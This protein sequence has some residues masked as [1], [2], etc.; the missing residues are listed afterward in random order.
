VSGGVPT[1]LELAGEY[2][3]DGKRPDGMSLIPWPWILPLLWDFTC[4]CTV[5][6]CRVSGKI[7]KYSCL[8]PSLY[9]SPICV[10]TLGAWG[11]CARSLVRQISPWVMEQSGDNRATQF[12]IQKVAIDVQRGNAASV[13]ATISSTQDWAEFAFLPSL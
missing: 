13:M 9:F 5:V 10:K 6:F 11:S 4:S 8:I 7:W 1:V 12:L 2:C 3:D